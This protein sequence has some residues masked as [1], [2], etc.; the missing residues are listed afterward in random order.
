[1][2]ERFGIQA[3]CDVLA[4]SNSNEIKN[5]NHQALSTF[6]ILKEHSR[7]E[8]RNWIEQL[9]GLGALQSYGDSYPVLKLGPKAK[10]IL[11]GNDNPPLAR[12]A[13]PINDAP[14][15]SLARFL[16]DQGLFDRLRTWR[17]ETA[18][19]SRVAPSVLFSDRVLA[20]LAAIRPSKIES[21]R[22]ITGI[23]EHQLR[24]HGKEIINAIQSYCDFKNVPM[25][26]PFQFQNSP[27]R[28]R[29]TQLFQ[30]KKSLAQIAAI[31]NITES[32]VANYLT[33]AILANEI[34]D[35]SPWLPHDTYSQICTAAAKV[36]AER[37]KP[38]Y[39]ELRETIPYALI[40]IALAYQ[41]TNPK[42]LAT[43]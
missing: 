40:R 37:L 30:E 39:D 35:I 24:I 16:Y 7:K 36:G 3:I 18:L 43:P 21:L 29:Y 32:T 15:K 23:G 34:R 26:Q 2:G 42:A 5:R 14:D 31:A 22:A 4:G 25:D 1:M 17:H 13:G 9:I 12:L 41:K 38:I 28:I 10:G 33:D 6:G 20:E 27:Q 19:K 8:I 11:F